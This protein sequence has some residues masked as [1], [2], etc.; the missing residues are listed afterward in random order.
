MPYIDTG[1]PENEPQRRW[2]P[3][4]ELHPNQDPLR[5]AGEFLAYHVETYLYDT[6]SDYNL[7]PGYLAW[8][9]AQFDYLKIGSGNPGQT[10]EE[11]SETRRAEAASVNPKQ[12][13]LDAASGDRNDGPGKVQARGVFYPPEAHEAGYVPQEDD[14]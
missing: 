1:A 6:D 13:A 12:L 9:V 8:A 3:H 10:Y 2:Q 11:F 14:A 5:R 4:R 7:D